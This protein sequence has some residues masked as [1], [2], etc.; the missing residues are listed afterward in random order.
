MDSDYLLYLVVETQDSMAKQ[1]GIVFFE[2]TM[3]GINFY[4]RKGVPTA[5]AAGGGFTRAAIK[6]GAHM[7]RVRE[8]NSEF[9]GCSRVNKIFKQSVRLFL[10]GYTDGTLHNRL[11]QLFLKLKDLDAVSER[12]KRCVALGIATAIGQQLLQDF[13][14]TPKRPVLLACAYGFD[15]ETLTFAATGVAVE[16][17][18][19]PA[20]ATY[21]E[22]VVGVVCY[23]FEADVYTRAVAPPLMMTRDFAGDGFSVT[24]PP[25]PEGTGVL[26][27]VA[28]VAFYQEVNGKGYL[29]S[30]DGAFGF[31]IVG[32][33]AT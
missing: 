23:D 17:L 26:Y 3:G 32:V 25:L 33:Q 10:A 8:S 20:E 24:V 28:R 15:W 18:G 29:L 13:V 16:Q 7:V 14:F 5:R 4:Y 22:L 9:A 19:F 30:G 21:M 11:I 6:N 31:A 1:R 12:G 27:A 2:G